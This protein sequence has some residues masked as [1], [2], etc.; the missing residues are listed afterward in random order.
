MTR[1]LGSKCSSVEPLV[2]YSAR[3]QLR[4]NLKQA[5]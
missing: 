2:D 4:N 5:V 1:V 3:C